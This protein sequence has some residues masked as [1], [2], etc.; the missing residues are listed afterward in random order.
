MSEALASPRGCRLFLERRKRAA[1]FTAPHETTKR[2][3]LYLFK[4]PSCSTSTASIFVPAGLVKRRRALAFVKRVIL[5][6][7]R[8]GLIQVVSASAFASTRQGNPSHVSQRMQRLF[9]LC[10]SFSRSPNGR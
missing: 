10:F 8:A 2:S 1:E 5:L 6:C 3:A 4:V 7:L 9:C